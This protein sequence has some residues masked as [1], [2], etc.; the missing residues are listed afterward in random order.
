LLRVARREVNRRRGWLGGATGPEL[1][2]LAHQSA[3]D[4]LLGVI[5]NLDSYRGDSRFTT[6]AYRLVVN[7]VSTKVQR[8]LWNGQQVRFGEV[9][10]DSLT[11]RLIPSPHGRSEQRAQLDA[12][13]TAVG[14][15]LTARQ[16]EVFV[17]VALNEIP[18]DAMASRLDS[19][20][21]AVYKTLFDARMK[22]RA[23]LAEA[24][25]PLEET[26]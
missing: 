7:H 9:D 13:R 10:W 4:A 15:I 12:L 21:G 20:R 1:D 23:Y 11:D 19:N 16:R 26:T 14:E 5:E 22:L 25:Y 8:H 18:I 2:D 3:N 24:G 17:R 6:W